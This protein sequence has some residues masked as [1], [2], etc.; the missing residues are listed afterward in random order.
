MTVYVTC[1][2]RQFGVSNLKL[3]DSEVE[4]NR[5]RVQAAGLAALLQGRPLRAPVSKPLRILDIGCGTGVVTELLASTYP[6]AEVI[7]VDI[8]PVP[9]SQHAKPTNVKYVQGDVRS[10]I[11]TPGFELGTFDYIYQRLLVMGM[12]DWPGHIEKISGLLVPG[13]WLEVQDVTTMVFS[14]SGERVYNKTK[15]FPKLKADCDSQGLDIF[16]GEKLAKLFE[17]CRHLSNVT[18]DVFRWSVLPQAEEPNL[19]A[20]EGQFRNLAI[21]LIG[22]CSSMRSEEER[23]EMRR[24]V[25]NLYDNELKL[26]DACTFHVVLGQKV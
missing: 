19:R 7:G 15:F 24:E 16:I 26:G 25:L 14:P 17:E 18:E 10:L 20:T 6:D 5:L 9:P 11:G 4:H 1:I 23:E 8:A 13:G 3:C 21:T 2:V 12:T 22:T